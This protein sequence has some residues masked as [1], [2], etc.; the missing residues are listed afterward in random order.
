M[1]SIRGSE[2]RREEKAPHL[3]SILEYFLR[4]NTENQNNTR[5]SDKNGNSNN[6]NDSNNSIVAP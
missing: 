4:E 2:N 6:D 5:N 3:Y 1:L